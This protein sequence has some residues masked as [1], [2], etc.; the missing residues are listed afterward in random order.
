MGVSGK[1]HAPAALLPGGKDPRYPLYRRLGGPQSRSGQ[2]LEE[3]SFRLC[4][5]SNLDRPVIQPV[6]RY[7]TDWATRLTKKQLLLLYHSKNEP[8]TP[9]E[10]PA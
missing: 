3:K 1:C 8:R 9:W 2:R 7:Y 5:G 4:R 6:A 10:I